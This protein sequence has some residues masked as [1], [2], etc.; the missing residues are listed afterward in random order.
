MPYVIVASQATHGMGFSAATAVEA[1]HIVD[2]LAGAGFDVER[3]LDQA[4]H[5]LDVADLHALADGEQAEE[6]QRGTRPPTP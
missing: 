2:E 4:S 3:V 5:E 1:L 6:R